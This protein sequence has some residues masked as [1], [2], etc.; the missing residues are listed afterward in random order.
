[1]KPKVLIVEDDRDLLNAMS[2]R[3]GAEHF[4][5]HSAT[6]GYS[7][8]Q[9]AQRVRPDILLLDL[10]LPGGDGL[11]VLTRFKTFPQL[12]SIPVVVV[13]ARGPE[14]EERA[15]SAGASAFLTKPVDNAKLVATLRSLLPETEAVQPTETRRRKIMLVEDDTDTRLA[16]QVRL[17]ASGFDVVGASDATSAMTLAMK[18]RPDLI[19]LD[20]GLPGGDGHLLLQRFKG[21]QQ[22][23]PTPVIILSARPP[24]GNQERALEAG[25]FAYLEKPVD[26]DR[27]LATIGAALEP[28]I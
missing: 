12:A 14:W 5:V 28:A 11:N 27:L 17:R 16:F 9:S 15:R 1:M 7:A 21:N 23:H 10:G 19:L 6:D 25:A 26:N 4:E 2:I 20:L 18:E 8:L 22:L 24:A 3:L 13:T